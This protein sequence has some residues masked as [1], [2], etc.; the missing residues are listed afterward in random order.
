MA[1]KLQKAI[2]AVRPGA[3]YPEWI[4]AGEEVDGRLQEIAVELG[5]VRSKKAAAAAPENK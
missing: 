4:E 5:A 1:M 2:Y 3:I